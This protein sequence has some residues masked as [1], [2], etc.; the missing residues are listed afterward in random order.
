MTP[1]RFCGTI[2]AYEARCPR[3]GVSASRRRSPP[4]RSQP[5]R[6][7]A[8]AAGRRVDRRSRPR[9][10]S[11]SCSAIVSKKTT[12]ERRDRRVQARD[13]ARSAGGRH[14]GASSPACTCGRTVQEAIATAEQALKIA[15]AN[16]E[17]HRVLG[18]RSTP[19]CR[20]SGA[21]TTPRAAA[22]ATQPTRTSRRRFSISSRRSTRADRRGRSE[23]R[24][25]CSRGCTSRATHTTRRFRCSSDLVKQEP[26]WQDGPGCW[27]KRTPAPAAHAEAIDVARRAA[28]D[29]P[30]LLPTLADFYERERRWTDAADAYERALQRAPRNIDLQVAVCVGA[31]ERRRP[32]RTSSRRATR[33][34]EARRDARTDERALYLLSQARAPPRRPRRRPRAT[35]RRL[36]APEQQEPVGLLRAGRSARGAP[37]VSAARRRAGAGDRDVPRHVRRSRASTLGMLLPHLGFAL[38]GARAVRQGD[39]RPSRKRASWRRRIRRSRAI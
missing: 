32:R 29:N 10:T 23:R 9:P 17:A 12:I 33:S 2:Q 8:A 38:S 11:S 25:R 24:A 7:S 37:P 1:S 5:Q 39:R 13:G 3:R 20:E 28:P 35:A 6:A 27:S 30:S 22:A 4:P 15:P 18:H 16:R 31:A 19:R 21:A 36:I 34:R 14:S 26:G